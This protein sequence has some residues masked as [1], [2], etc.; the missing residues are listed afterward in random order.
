MDTKHLLFQT[1]K[2]F[3][4]TKEVKCSEFKNYIDIKYKN[5]KLKIYFS[6]KK[7]RVTV[8]GKCKKHL[9]SDKWSS[10][11]GDCLKQLLYYSTDKDIKQS[12]IVNY[13]LTLCFD[14]DG[15][16]K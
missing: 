15:N 11:K 10:T 14:T 12:G 16:K 1:I 9:C 4:N 8:C 3:I 13:F 2:K 6:D 5:L 7:V